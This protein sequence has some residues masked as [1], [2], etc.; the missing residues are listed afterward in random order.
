MSLNKHNFSDVQFGRYQ[1]RNN[2]IVEIDDSREVET[3]Q[4]PGKEPTKRTV[5]SGWVLLADGRT[6]DT[7]KDYEIDGSFIGMNGVAS[8]DDLV[9]LISLGVPSAA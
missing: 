4:A 6:R 7:R 1:N 3:P 9:S 5:F 2:R 8:G